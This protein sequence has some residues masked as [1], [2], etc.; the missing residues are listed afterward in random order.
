MPA[1][2]E[3]QRELMA[4]ALHTPKKLWKRNRSVLTMT[5]KQLRDF[6]KRKR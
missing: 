4:I 5:K 1:K 6:A 2:T 3:K